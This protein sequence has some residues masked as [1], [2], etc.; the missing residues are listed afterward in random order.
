MNLIP[1]IEEQ[2]AVQF[3]GKINVLSKIN[4][5]FLGHLL[6]KDG[7]L[8]EVKYKTMDG[9]K[10][11]FQI[12]I[13]E[14]L[15]H[16]FHYVV[17]PEIVEASGRKIHFPFAVL[18]NKLGDVLKNYQESVKMRPPNHL[19]M[20]VDVS[21]LNKNKNLDQNEYEVLSTLTEWSLISD[22]YEKCQLLDHEIT[23]S[24]V[25]L[26]KKGALKIIAPMNKDI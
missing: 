4:R 24:L 7:E 6:I 25:S 26:R 23:L 5:Q 15:L 17:E 14:F 3:T 16:A 19:K 18:K 8:I 13:D 9:L 11:F 1:L 21:F 22:V 2:V 20:V 10:G 12:C